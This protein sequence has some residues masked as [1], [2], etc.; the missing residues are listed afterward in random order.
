MVYTLKNLSGTG[1]AQSNSLSIKEL[2][3]KHIASEAFFYQA[4]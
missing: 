2:I 3:K 1:F 4:Y